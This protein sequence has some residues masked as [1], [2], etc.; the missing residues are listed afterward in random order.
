LAR[1]LDPGL[2]Q[3]A[4]LYT[5][6]SGGLDAPI[7]GSLSLQT[8]RRGFSSALSIDSLGAVDFRTRN[9]AAKQSLSFSSQTT[10]GTFKY[11][12]TQ[13]TPFN[14][15]D[16][17]WSI[18]RNNDGARAGML[19]RQALTQRIKV[20]FLATHL[21]GG[22]AGSIDR[23]LLAVRE[24][25][26][27]QLVHLNWGLGQPNNRHWFDFSLFRRQHRLEDQDAEFSGLAG[28]EPRS[29]QERALL[30]WRYKAQKSNYGF[31]WRS[32]V[33]ADQIQRQPN[34]RLSVAAGQRG[35]M[36]VGASLRGGQRTGLHG[37]AWLSGG[38]VTDHL[39][40]LVDQLPEALKN[41]A[42][43]SPEPDWAPGLSLAYASLLR[44]RF[45]AG[46]RRPSVLELIGQHGGLRG[47]P[48]LRAER[49]WNLDLRSRWVRSI[50]A[51]QFDAYARKIDEL[52]DWSATS[53]GRAMPVN[54]AEV[55]IIGAQ[56]KARLILGAFRL[57]SAYRY[58]DEWAKDSSQA[59]QAK[60][61]SGSAKH[62]LDLRA[63]YRKQKWRW[64]LGFQAQSQRFLDAAN[65]RA[66]DS[67]PELHL[68]LA[69]Q[70]QKSLT[71]RLQLFNATHP[72]T[73]D[74]TLWPGGY[75]R[76]VAHQDRWGQALPGRRLEL[77][78][79][80]MEL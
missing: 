39:Q 19:W 11:L 15:R 28:L 59:P 26:A 44:L 77:G 23:P 57:Q 38:Q 8:P 69:W 80:L 49:S 41:S 16:D 7:A 20:Q 37:L 14:R 33:F 13:G 50:I 47:N 27:L 61:L 36:R 62:R 2:F 17:V 45:I 63:L 29:S 73:A 42:Q 34:P 64:G 31:E 22:V 1:S 10:T 75:T 71:I 53:F 30:Q 18:R 25:E 72:E 43:R 58:Q 24:S 68:L 32:R 21:S 76:P 79:Q 70:P 4:R 48:T 78:I 40:A 52:I 12:D 56:L 51:L 55:E 35:L 65:L 3:G 67:A 66:L 46:L 60:R 9:A 6:S 54:R 74:L 5:G